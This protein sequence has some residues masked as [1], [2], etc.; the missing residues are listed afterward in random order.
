MRQDARPRHAH[1]RR[2]GQHGLPPAPPSKWNAAGPQRACH[3]NL[4]VHARP[5]PGHRGPRPR[6]SGQHA[7]AHRPGWR[8]GGPARLVHHRARRAAH[9][10]THREVP[11][12]RC[13]G[14]RSS[15]SWARHRPAPGFVQA[16]QGTRIRDTCPPEYVGLRPETGIP[17]SSVRKIIA[18]CGF[19]VSATRARQRYRSTASPSAHA[20]HAIVPAHHARAQRAPLPATWWPLRWRHP[21]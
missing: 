2:Y 1:P 5:C 15:T 18:Q 14:R 11:A 17:R 12:Y 8:P 19:P 7:P 20:P 16:R 4:L 10:A 9:C 21:G 3:P 13:A 6:W